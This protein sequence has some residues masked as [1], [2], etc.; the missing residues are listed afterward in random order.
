RHTRFSRDWSSDVCSSDLRFVGFSG[1]SALAMES[2]SLCR[3][4]S[5]VVATVSRH[6]GPGSVLVE[7]SI[8]QGGMRF[9]VGADGPGPPGREYEDR[10]SVVEGEGVERG[11]DR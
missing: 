5:S 8:E 9:E 3:T 10:K 2:R 7:A 1:E 11:R 6:L 4:L